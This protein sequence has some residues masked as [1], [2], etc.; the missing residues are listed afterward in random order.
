L[1]YHDPKTNLNE[2]DTNDFVGRNMPRLPHFEGKKGLKLPY[3]LRKLG[4][5]L[6]FLLWIRSPPKKKRKR[7]KRKDHAS[8]HLNIATQYAVVE[9]FYRSK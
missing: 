7:K 2:K 1:H 4:S 8:N 5:F 3:W 9:P 6:S